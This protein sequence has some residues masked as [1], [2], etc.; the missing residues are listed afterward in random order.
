MSRKIIG[1]L[2]LALALPLAACDD[3]TAAPAPGTLSLMLTDEAGD[4]TQAW[5]TIERIYLAGDGEGDGEEEPILDTPFTTNLL[6]LSNDIEEI[7]EDETIPGGVYSQLRFVIPEACIGVEQEDQSELVY[8]SDG[9]DEC[10]P[11]DGSLQLPS[12]GSSGLKVT[13]PGGSLEVDGDAHILLLDFDVA[14]SFGHDTGTDKWVLNPVIHADDIS[15]SSGIVVELTVSDGVD[16]DAIGAS[17]GDFEA[18]LDTETEP[19]AFTDPDEDGVFTAV[20]EFLMPDEEYEVS[21]GLQ[22]DATAFDYTLDPTS[23]QSVSLGSA[24]QATITFE[25]TSAAPSS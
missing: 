7:V 20:F 9:F 3:G 23:P 11:A 2:T 14:Q 6:T 5:V 8:A 13:F 12:L 19:L 10:G 18:S 21:V 25:V 16:L 17:L 22:E 1:V 15:L 24:E 4:F